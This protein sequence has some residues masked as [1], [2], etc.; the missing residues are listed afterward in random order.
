M[1]RI[2]GVH[3][4]VDRVVDL[5]VAGG[6]ELLGLHATLAPLRQQ[7][8]APVLE[9]FVFVPYS[10]RG[11]VGEEDEEA[12]R[13]YAAACGACVA[14]GLDRLLGNG[15]TQRLPNAALLKAA[16]QKASGAESGVSGGSEGAYK[17]AQY[18]LLATL[19]QVFESPA[20]GADFVAQIGDLLESRRPQLATDA[21][22]TRC[23]QPACLK[24]CL[25][26]VLENRAGH[27]GAA[28]R[29]V[30]QGGGGVYRHAVPQLRSQPG[31]RL[32]YSLV[33]SE[34]PADAAGLEVGVVSGAGRAAAD[35][36]VASGWLSRQ[37][38]VAAAL[39]ALAGGARDD[40]FVLV[41]EPTS[42]FL[43][44]L[45]LYGLVHDLSGAT[46]LDARTFG[47]FCDEPT[48]ERLMAAAGLEVVARKADGLLST[49]W[50]CRVPRP[51]TPAAPV[52]D[53]VINVDDLQY[54]WVDAVKAAMA[55]AQEA[56]PGPTVWLRATDP[57]VHTG[58]VGLVNCL[59]QEPGGGTIR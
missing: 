3:V 50:L 10:Q 29:V 14:R 24:A 44:P 37:P 21:L 13:G 7:Q 23:L 8:A 55:S 47:P 52:P 40:G 32:E 59:R 57:R 18:G 25:D 42:H 30:E 56:P 43:V 39:A 9:E 49:L 28:L 17:G 19:R 15:V 36:V 51:A 58:V 20:D 31:M 4:V 48:W 46:D 35:L 38:D 27:A 54:G 16:L 45:V 33:A 53:V 41:H 12:V 11:A 5:C 2:A 22:L 26:V 34:A 6:V 1:R